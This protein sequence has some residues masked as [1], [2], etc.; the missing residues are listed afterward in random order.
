VSGQSVHAEGP[1]GKLSCE[2]PSVLKVK[3]QDGRIILER[4]S[5]AKQTKALHGLYRSLIANMIKGVS[6]GFQKG[7]EIVGVGY[8]VRLRG[9]KFVLNVGF[10]AP[11]EVKIPDG[12]TVE[13]PSATRFYI[14]GV[15]KQKVGEFAAEVRGI[16]PPEPYKGKG[17]RYEKE[18]V[19]RKAGKSVI[20]AG[21]GK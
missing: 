6:K 3:I 8:G 11:V 16:R 5:D 19:R 20:G 4:I 15:D 21:V 1:V 14:R 2:V 18:V 10:S 9:D 17:I 12:L 13:A 7:L